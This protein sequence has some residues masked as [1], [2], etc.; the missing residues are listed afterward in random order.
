VTASCVSD[1]P[2]AQVYWDLGDAAGR[3]PGATFTRTFPVAALRAHC[4]VEAANGLS[5]HDSAFA[6]APDAAPCRMMFEPPSGAAPL[7]VAHSIETLPALALNQVIIGADG[8]AVSPGEAIVYPEGFHYVRTEN[9]LQDGTV[10]CVDRARVFAYRRPVF[11]SMPPTLRCGQALSYA[12]DVSGGE[13]EL[14]SASDGVTFDPTTRTV[15]GPA[16]L[17]TTQV[18]YQL[19]A[20]NRFD[21]AV[22]TEQ[23]TVSC[24]DGLHFHTPCG[25]QSPAAGPALVLLLALVR[26]AT[27]RR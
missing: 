11:N 4:Y 15:L 14:S 6:G 17:K 1:D 19:R 5:A 18:A 3:M 21:D 2:T 24:G 12:V 16:V 25:C 13:V 20:R 7:G 26:R 23:Q 22:Q 27:R 10:R 8:G 9:Q